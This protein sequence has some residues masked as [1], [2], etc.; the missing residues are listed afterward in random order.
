MTCI[1]DRKVYKLS[2]LYFLMVEPDLEAGLRSLRNSLQQI[3]A[4]LAWEQLKQSE[5]KPDQSPGFTIL[6]D[7]VGTDLRNEYSF[8]LFTSMQIH[9]ILKDNTADLSNARRQLIKQQLARI[10][11]QLYRLGLH[12]RFLLTSP[13]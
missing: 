11:H 10:E 1:I 3:K 5:A 4:L 12:E 13:T 7:S 2:S 6:N 9:S 8:F